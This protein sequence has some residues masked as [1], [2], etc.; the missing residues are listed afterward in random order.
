[1]QYNFKG[2]FFLN[3]ELGNDKSENIEF[4]NERKIIDIWIRD[5]PLKVI[6][7]GFLSSVNSTGVMHIKSGIRVPLFF[8]REQIITI[9]YCNRVRVNIV[10]NICFR[11]YRDRIL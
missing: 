11:V 3:S 1:M 9:I 6:T 2:F 4:G 7:H 10:E 5:R 8:R